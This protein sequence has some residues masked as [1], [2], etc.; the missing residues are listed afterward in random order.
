MNITKTQW[1]GLQKEWFDC[2]YAAMQPVDAV[3]MRLTNET[4]EVERLANGIALA[5]HKNRHLADGDN[6]T[7]IDL[8]RLVPDWEA[9]LFYLLRNN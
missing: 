7:L 5:L 4:N 9:R 6:C 1:K 8:K 3:R 2:E